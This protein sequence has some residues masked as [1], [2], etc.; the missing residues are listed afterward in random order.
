MDEKYYEAR[1]KLEKL[2]NDAWYLRYG[3]YH[4]THLQASR[5][6]ARSILKKERSPAAAVTKEAN[7]EAKKF[8]RLAERMAEDLA[9]LERERTIT[10]E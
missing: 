4:V 3:D 1:V 5:E 8:P 2:L 9:A 7:P 6:E 10:D